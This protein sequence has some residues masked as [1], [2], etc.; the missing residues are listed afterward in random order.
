M[1]IALTTKKSKRKNE[2][3]ASFMTIL[4]EVKESRK[5]PQG[6]PP[7]PSPPPPRFPSCESSTTCKEET[8]RGSRRPNTG[9]RRQMARKK[10]TSQ[11]I[12]FNNIRE[13]EKKRKKTTYPPT[14]QRNT[15]THI[16]AK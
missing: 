12:I 4:S 14:S 8:Y 6:P 5:K 11:Q 3:K 9:I 10:E 2:G 15:P 1:K 7:S 16:H 13:K